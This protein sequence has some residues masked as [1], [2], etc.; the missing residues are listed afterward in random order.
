MLAPNFRSALTATALQSRHRERKHRASAQKDKRRDVV[1]A[2]DRPGWA[3]ESNERHTEDF[4]VHSLEE[5]FGGRHIIECRFTE[6]ARLN[7]PCAVL[8]CRRGVSWRAGMASGRQ[9]T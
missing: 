4:I 8:L 6:S 3:V 5:L 9:Q 1:G 7:L 2:V